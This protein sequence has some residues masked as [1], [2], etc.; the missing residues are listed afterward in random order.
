MKSRVI[1]N[2]RKLHPSWQVD[3]AFNAPHSRRRRADTVYSPVWVCLFVYP[4][5]AKSTLKSCSAA[6]LVGEVRT[7]RDELSEYRALVGHVAAH[8]TIH[9]RRQNYV[10]AAAAFVLTGVMLWLVS[11]VP[12]VH[13]VQF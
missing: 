11:H 7:L 2:R 12:S 8:L 9:Q 5:E 1:S 4:M 13:D 6:D 3:L 10:F